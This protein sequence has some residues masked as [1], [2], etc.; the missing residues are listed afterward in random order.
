[1][2]Y[3]N[4]KFVKEQV[5]PSQREQLVEGLMDILVRLMHRNA[6]LTVVTVDEVEARN[7]LIGGRPLDLTGNRRGKVAYVNI[8]IS[9]G[10]S[11]PEEMASVIRAG[12]E[13]IVNVL[14]NSE[15]TNYFI[16]EELNPDGWG[17]DGI[18]M[19][20]RNQQEKEAFGSTP[21]QKD[22]R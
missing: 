19:T 6:E 10:T 9:K 16:I 15:E 7:W 3:V 8:K 20:V 5:S 13:L 12:K 14:G 2:P 1:M 4:L 22:V 21:P 18:S 17:F 11:H